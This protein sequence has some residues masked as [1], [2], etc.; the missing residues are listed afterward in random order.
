MSFPMQQ[1]QNTSLPSLT[2]VTFT[3]LQGGQFLNYSATTGQWQNVSGSVTG[4]QD[5]EDV[6]GRDNSAGAFG[7]NMNS[8]NIT[9]VGTLAAATV[10][11]STGTFGALTYT[12]LNPPIPGV[13]GLADTLAVSNSAGSNNID[14]NDQNITNCDAIT[15]NGASSI[16]NASLMSSQTVSILTNGSLLAS[17][18]GSIQLAETDMQGNLNMK[19]TDNVKNNILEAGVIAGETISASGFSGNEG[20]I[21]AAREVSTS[22]YTVNTPYAG[23]PANSGIIFGSLITAPTQ[24][25]GPSVT[26]P[27]TCTN[28]D[29][30][31][32]T[33]LFTSSPAEVYEW[34]GVVT[35]KIHK[36]YSRHHHMRTLDGLSR[37]RP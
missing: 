13:E 37:Y 29:L 8:Q 23:Q 26:N 16:T 9:S 32:A 31:S 28:L 22:I 2:D 33:S 19:G 12:T 1:E 30:R 6:L 5:L 15:A 14:M 34:G 17:G 3:N 27:T 18:A 11:G 21:S 35:G 24:L 7:I 4:K 36:R 25:T 10:T 20:R